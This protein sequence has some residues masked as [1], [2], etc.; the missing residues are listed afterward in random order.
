[1]TWH[2]NPAATCANCPFWNRVGH[3]KRKDGTTVTLGECRQGPPDVVAYP[4]AIGPSIAA[5]NSVPGMAYVVERVVFMAAADFWCGQHP[6]LLTGVPGGG[7][8]SS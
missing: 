6:D 1:M 7:P 5:P 2:R 4:K 3:Q 8:P